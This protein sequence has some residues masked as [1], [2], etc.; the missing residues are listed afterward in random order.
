MKDR[1]PH[2]GKLFV[3]LVT[4]FGLISAATSIPG[5]AT[6]T[7][8]QTSTPTWNLTG[9]LNVG[10][11]SH[12]ATLLRNGKVLVAGGNN[13]NG[14]LKSAELYNPA[15]GAWSNTGNLNTDRA[16]HTATMLL[17]GKV[18]VA[19]G[20]SCAPPPA[21]CFYLNSAELY[22]PT[23]G[24]WTSTGNLHTAR[25]S[26]TATMLPNGNVLIAGGHNEGSGALL[27]AELYDP[28]AGTW[29]STGNLNVAAPST[30][31]RCC[32]KPKCW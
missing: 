15:T 1:T 13:S 19:G 3:L 6:V 14:S 23:A 7:S 11:D 25:G 5:S 16:F 12:T 10:R 26:H 24:T 22:D 9:N 20:F 31:R 32:S 30:Q 21:S 4:V 29:T 18:L 28:I 2:A 8:V 17:N 27:S